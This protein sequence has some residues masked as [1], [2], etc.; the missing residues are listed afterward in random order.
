MKSILDPSFSYTASFN[1]DVQKTFTRVLRDRQK[2]AESAALANVVV[3]A[4]ISTAVRK[5]ETNR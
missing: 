3:K 5:P 4:G 1:T 2:G